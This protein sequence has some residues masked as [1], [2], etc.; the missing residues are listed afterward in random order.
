MGSLTY[1]EAKR[2]LDGYPSNFKPRKRRTRAADN[3]KLA[4][5][6]YL[7]R[8]LSSMPEAKE[9][10]DKIFLQLHGANIV[11]FTP[12]YMEFDTCGWPTMTT[13]ER[14]RWTPVNIGASK[15]G[16]ALFPLVM[17]PCYTCKGTLVNDH[18]DFHYSE[19][20]VTPDDGG[21]PYHP[22]IWTPAPCANCDKTGKV[23]G[24][25][26][27]SGGHPFYDGIRTD[28]K[29]TRLLR[30]QPNRPEVFEPLKTMSGYTG[31]PIR[32]EPYA[33]YHGVNVSPGRY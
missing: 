20:L 6:T 8:F 22:A 26:W 18:D 10:H 16:W 14:M 12:H 24:F 13:S 17:R 19:E 30:R 9:L 4:N 29:G 11:T 27:D 21:T 3:V 15:G 33:S 23:E 28:T 25:D 7:V 1:S 32:P 2:I 31:G 5:N